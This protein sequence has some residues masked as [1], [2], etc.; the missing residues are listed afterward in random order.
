MFWEFIKFARKDNTKMAP[1]LTHARI[2]WYDITDSTNKELRRH[3]DALDNLSFVAAK[4]QVAGRGQGDHVW[5]SEAGANLTFSMLLRFAPGE[6][7]ARD[8]QLI[9]ALVTPVMLDFLASEGVEA[10][11]KAPN[12]IWVKDKKI[13]GILVENILEGPYVRESIIG[14]GFNLNQ[15]EWP[16]DL[17]NPVS[18]TQL[19]GRTYSPEKVLQ[20][21]AGMFEERCTDRKSC[22]V[23]PR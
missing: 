4:S 13:A 23:Q 5:C 12:D 16:S 10:W 17:P 1:F 19:T 20:I 2:K 8:E 22:P 21:L 15:T 9:N 3:I 11:V 6:L 14:I 7:K 18:L